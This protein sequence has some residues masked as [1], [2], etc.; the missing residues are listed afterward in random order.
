MTSAAQLFPIAIATMLIGCSDRAQPL[1]PLVETAA[2]AASQAAMVDISGTWNYAET[3]V[4]VVKPGE[5]VI[6]IIC[7]SPDGVLTIDQ[8][9]AT[10]TGTLTH[11][12]SICETKDGQIVPAP[13]PMPYEAVLSGRISGRSLHIDQFDAP[14]APPVHCVKQGVVRVSDGAAISLQTTGR[15]DLSLVP[16]RPA[17]ARNSATAT[18]P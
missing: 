11:P 2:V 9:G 16:F 14:P 8:S 18:R 15:C 7:T 10:F 5:E 3:S 13:W 17:T 4:L 12:T 6:H 1:A